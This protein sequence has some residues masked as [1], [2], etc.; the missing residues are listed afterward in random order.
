M[1]T[2]SPGTQCLRVCSVTTR[3]YP[4]RRQ[5]AVRLI[6]VRRPIPRN[7]SHG[8]S[9]RPFRVTSWRRSERRCPAETASVASIGGMQRRISL[10]PF[11]E[12]TRHQ[13]RR[14]CTRYHPAD[15]RQSEPLVAVVIEPHHRDCLT[16]DESIARNGDFI[17]ERPPK[18]PELLG[19][20]VNV[21]RDPLDGSSRAAGLFF[22][23][24]RPPY[25]PPHKAVLDRQGDPQPKPYTPLEYT[26]LCRPLW[27]QRD[28]LATHG[29]WACLMANGLVS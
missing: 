20:A 15:S 25:G 19:R 9:N 7:L 27:R 10:L 2:L 24:W 11:Q 28:F 16:D 1:C 14:R 18:G 12:V 23:R 5:P 4:R 22:A 26:E 3:L 8:L 6:T 21:D 13:K 17:L 29:H